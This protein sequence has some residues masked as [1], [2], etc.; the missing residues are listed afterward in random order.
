MPISSRLAPVMLASAS[1]QGSSPSC[2][3]VPS[4]CTALLPRQANTKSTAYSGSTATR[5]S[6]E[7]ASP[8]EIS[9]DANSAAHDSTNA[10]PT[11]ARPNTRASSGGVSSGWGRPMSRATPR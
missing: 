9:S 10:A 3:Q 11:T 1:E 7:I 4:A 2:W 5:A 6:T 8:A